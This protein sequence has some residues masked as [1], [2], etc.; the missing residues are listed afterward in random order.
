MAIMAGT[1]S[2]RSRPAPAEALARIRDRLVRPL[3]ADGWWGWLIP[4]AITAVAL[5]MRLWRITRPQSKVFDETYYAHDAW[6]LLHHGVELDANSHDQTP[7]FVAH[8][9]LGKWAIALGEWIWGNNP[10]GWRFSA[11]IFGSL[12]ILLIARIARRLFRSTLLGCVA[13]LL[14]SFDGLEFVQSRTSMLDIFLMFWVL[15]AFGCLLLDRDQGRRRIADALDAPLDFASRGPWLGFRPW[16]W[17]CGLCLGAAFATKWDGIFWV[18]AFFVLALFWDAGARRVAGAKQP[19]VSALLYD[20][21]FALVPFV[22]LVAAVYVASWTGWF[23]SDG[24]HAWNHDRYVHAGQSWFAHD[25]AV[26]GG[27][28]RYHWEMW[29]FH[30]HLDAAHPYLSRPYGWL[31]LARPVSYYYST[32][33]DCGSLSCAQEVVALGTPALW[34]AVIPALIACIWRAIGRL[35][36]RAAAVVVSFLAGFLPWFWADHEHRTTFLFYMLPAL[37]FMVL[38]VTLTLGLVLGRVYAST[39]RHTVGTVAVG[40]YLLA[41]IATFGYLYPVLAGKVLTYDQWHRRMWFHN[42]D[43]SKNRDEHNENAPCWI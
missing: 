22:V 13:A 24:A 37:P 36:W 8:P 14:L 27:W 20:G 15:A 30:R 5:F 3:P 40:A 38:A 4:L 21:L 28:W 19:L 39:L 32:S 9:P 18:P 2:E 41:V 34:W 23:L 29:N 12:A 42:C 6:D 25:R 10:L 11:A 17:A 43:T 1:A 33:G 26:L 35:D 7:G 31:L 16:R